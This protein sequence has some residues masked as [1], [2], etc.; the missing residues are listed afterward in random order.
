MERGETDTERGEAY[1]FFNC[2]ASPDEIGQ[3]LGL[4]QADLNQKQ[5]ARGQ[6]P[7]KLETKLTIRETK[8]L[9]SDPKTDRKLVDGI[10]QDPVQ[11]FVPEALRAQKYDPILMKDLKYVVS[12]ETPGSNYDAAEKLEPVMNGIAW[13]YAQDKPFWMTVVCRGE[14][15]YGEYQTPDEGEKEEEVSK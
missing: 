4:V 7:G 13:Y 12:I 6:K 1:S 5:E 9:I 8:D 15:D 3:Y 10:L 11:P 2:D 14:D